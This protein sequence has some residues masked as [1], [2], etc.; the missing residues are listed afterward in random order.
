MNR[1]IAYYKAVKNSPM[2]NFILISLNFFFLI[3]KLSFYNLISKL[4]QIRKKI[5][6]KKNKLMKKGKVKVNPKIKK[7]ISRINQVQITMNLMHNQKQ[8]ILKKRLIAMIKLKSQ[9]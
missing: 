5:N 8:K 4:L 3:R 1:L 6:L 2:S 7:L 9:N